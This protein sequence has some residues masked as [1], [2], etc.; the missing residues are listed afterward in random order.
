[1]HERL[2]RDRQH[3][4][5]AA[6]WPVGWP[7]DAPDRQLSVYESQRTMQLHRDCEMPSCPR[8]SAA[9]QVLVEAKKIQP[10]S[11]RAY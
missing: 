8:K 6:R 11:S 5:K 9:W 4:A 1:M 7:H 2:Q 10:D 3:A